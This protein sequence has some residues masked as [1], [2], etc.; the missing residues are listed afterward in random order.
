[1]SDR[2]Y[3]MQREGIEPP[4]LNL[5]V[6]KRG[7]WSILLKYENQGYFQ[8]AFGFDCVDHDYQ[9]GDVGMSLSEHLFRTFMREDLFPIE[10]KN[11]SAFLLK[12]KRLYITYTHH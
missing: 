6:L 9:A 12:F 8:T 7:F 3:F 1:M 11:I 5:E 4:P 2:Q 10:P